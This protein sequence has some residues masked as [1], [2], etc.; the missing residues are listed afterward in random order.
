VRAARR[1]VS[2]EPKA[3]AVICRRQETITRAAHL[4]GLLR[5]L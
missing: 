5:L 2:Q 3:A 4:S 1:H